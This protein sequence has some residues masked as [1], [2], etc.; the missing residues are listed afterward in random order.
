MD[1]LAYE[2]EEEDYEIIG[3]EKIIMSPAPKIGH[4]T[5]VSRLIFIFSNYIEENDIN[6]IA[7]GDN[8][9]VY[10]SDD[11]HF[12]PDVSVIIRKP[13]VTSDEAYIDG[14]P[15]LVVEVLSEST[16]KNDTGRKKDAYEK[17]GVREYWIVDPTFK[18]IEVYHLIEG[19]FNKYDL[20]D[21]TKIK[22]SIF[23]ELVVD[24]FSVFKWLN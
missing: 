15:D 21:N 20:F 19:K 11:N 18:T 8:A 23:E 4:G 24:V 12:R 2:F 3:G 13:I 16:R 7:L 6:A 9:D 10:L 5:I 22:V 1:N 17:Y 14:A